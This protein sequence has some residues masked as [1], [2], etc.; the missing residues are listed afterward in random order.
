MHDSKQD[1]LLRL[2][3]KELSARLR[4]QFISSSKH[5]SNESRNSIPKENNTK[6]IQ[7]VCNT[8]ES[9]N[10]DDSS[11]SPFLPT[12]KML[13]TS[14]ELALADWR[15]FSEIGLCGWGDNSANHRVIAVLDALDGGKVLASEQAYIDAMNREF[16]INELID[17]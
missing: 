9:E 4:Q 5:G 8:G 17:R 11:R 1:T 10:A 13:Q 16:P 6:N 12:L 2:Y 14:L 3:H 7:M 15:R